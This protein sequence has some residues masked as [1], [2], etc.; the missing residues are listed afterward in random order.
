MTREIVINGRFLSHRITGVQRYGSEIV[1]LIGNRC[2]IEK[3]RANGA[4]GHLWEQFL[5]P[6][7]L[8]SNSVLWSPGNTGPLMVREQALTIH[9]LSPLEHPEWFRASFS[10]W[11][12]LFLPILA[13]RVRVIFTPSEYMRR[14][15][16]ARIGVN[17]VLSV[18]SGVNH[19][20]FHP[21]VSQS[22]CELPKRYVLFVGSLEPR[23]N[24]PLLLKAWNE[25]YS[26]FPDVT[27]LIVGASGRIFRSVDFQHIPPQTRFLG[28][29]EKELPL[30]YAN[31]ELFALPSLE[32]GFGLPALEAMA[33]GTAVV[34]SNGGALPEVVGDAALIFNLADS[35]ALAKALKTCL[36][37]KDLRRLLREKGLARAQQFSWHVTAHII[38]QTLNEL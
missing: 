25:I 14:K 26:E 18:P 23:K 1:R 28:Y 13:K 29:V 5:L 33:C 36:R 21:E 4:V 38:W 6:H 16:T 32:E 15:I 3:T 27:L 34:V 31:A 9:D 35:A 22:T 10:F 2:R 7:K 17:N 30:L 19:E 20:M 11:Y 12:R 24:L 8:G 37:D